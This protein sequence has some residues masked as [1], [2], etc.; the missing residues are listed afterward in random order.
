MSI[1]NAVK[2]IA[3]STSQTMSFEFLALVVWGVATVSVCNL[4]EEQNDDRAGVSYTHSAIV[5]QSTSSED[6]YA[7]SE[8]V[9]DLGQ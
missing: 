3:E 5:N 1:G 9:K 8:L 2:E 7:L 4:M 6:R